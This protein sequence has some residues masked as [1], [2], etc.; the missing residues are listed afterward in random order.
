MFIKENQLASK[1]ALLGMG[2]SGGHAALMSC[3]IEPYL[4]EGV[5]VHNPICD[6]PSYLMYDLADKL[7]G[8]SQ[9]EF[10]E[11]QYLGIQEFGDISQLEV[12]QQAQ[13]M[14]PYHLPMSIRPITDLLISV[15]EDHPYKYHSRKLMGKLRHIKAGDPLYAFYR[16]F[17]TKM[18]SQQ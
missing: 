14:S 7:P 6:L 3:F 9:E 8:V 12:Y 16:E 2:S 18:Y 10:A 4:F 13:L 5:S 17:P 1:L 11:R 15:D